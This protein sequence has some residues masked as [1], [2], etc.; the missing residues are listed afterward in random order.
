[1]KKLLSISV[2]DKNIRGSGKDSLIYYLMQY[3]RYDVLQYLIEKGIYP[4]LSIYRMEFGIKIFV[5]P[6]TDVKKMRESGCVSRRT[7]DLIREYHS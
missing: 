3:D 5:N 7:Y 2:L 4:R 6:Y 1:M